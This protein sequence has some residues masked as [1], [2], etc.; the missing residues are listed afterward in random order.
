MKEFHRLVDSFADFK[1]KWHAVNMSMISQVVPSISN[2]VI[3]ILITRSLGVDAY[4]NYVLV[5]LI[6]LFGLAIFKSLI[7][8][9]MLSYLPERNS[10]EHRLVLGAICIQ[11]FLI[12]ILFSAIVGIIISF[13][14]SFLDIYYCVMFSV[15]SI[16]YI[17]YEFIKRYLLAIGFYNE[18]VKFDLIFNTSYILLLLSS[19]GTGIVTEWQQVY[20]LYGGLLLIFVVYLN[21]RYDVFVF[22]TEKFTEYT[23]KSWFF[24][25]WLMYSAILQWVMGNYFVFITGVMLDA[26]YAGA[27][28]ALQNIV[29]LVRV[30]LDGL[31]NV[32]PRHAVKI[33]SEKG[34]RG[35]DIYLGRITAYIL[36]F[37]VVIIL[38]YGLY[39]SQIILF[40]Y[41]KSVSVDN[42]I[43]LMYSFLNIVLVFVFSGLMYLRVLEKT[44]YI[45]ASYSIAALLMLCLVPTLVYFYGIIGAISSVVIVN[46]ILMVILN[47]WSYHSKKRMVEI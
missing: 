11:L 15:F 17:L 36:M 34:G 30:L 16:V 6:V 29:V 45:F 19:I 2:L 18:A 13:V 4:G 9:P 31:E 46:F 39:P 28:R 26:K 41:G 20:L 42:G 8:A 38:L 10:A 27:L 37:S 33:F 44:R 14:I 23:K 35:L 40:I 32:V 7:T 21:Y 5:W 12:L 24:C 25:R 43:V 1:N 3:A 22:H 47:M